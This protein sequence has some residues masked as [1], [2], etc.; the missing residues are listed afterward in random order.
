MLLPDPI[1]SSHQLLFP[2]AVP[3][4]AGCPD[5]TTRVVTAVVPVNVGTPT[6][7]IRMQKLMSQCVVDLLLTDQMIVA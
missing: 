4:Q 6:V 3:A 2:I 7:I 5:L 1:V